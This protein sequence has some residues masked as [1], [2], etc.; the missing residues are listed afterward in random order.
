ME[1]W[2][3]CE[4]KLAMALPCATSQTNWQLL[5]LCVGWMLWKG[6]WKAEDG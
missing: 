5:D 3:F 2:S 6:R 1:S 4:R